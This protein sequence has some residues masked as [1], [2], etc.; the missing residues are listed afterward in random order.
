M[1]FLLEMH[2]KRDTIFWNIKI[3]RVIKASPS[4]GV[5]ST[6]GLKITLLRNI[7]FQTVC[8]INIH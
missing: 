8:F 3:N 2:N 5:L 7:N 1:R 6:L 4:E